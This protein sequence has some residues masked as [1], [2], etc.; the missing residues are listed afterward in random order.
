MALKSV[1]AAAALMVVAAPGAAQE[2]DASAEAPIEMNAAER[3]AAF[4]AENAKREGVMGTASGLQYQIVEKSPQNGR[5]PKSNSVV[6]VH[7]IG[8][9]M[10]GAVF[11][12]SIARGA[13]D[14]FR[15]DSVIA[16][17]S[18]GLQLMSV[19]DKFRFFIPP[20]LAYGEAGVPAAKIGPDELLIFD[21]ELIRVGRSSF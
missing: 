15:V 4:L 13:P 12:S 1:M 6:V 17:W 7:Y 3:S 19:G 2:G 5:R 9:L 11:D 16:G 20:D 8:M 14:T 10:N 21:V 18:E